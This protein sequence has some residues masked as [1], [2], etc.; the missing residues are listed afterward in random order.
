MLR[1][2]DRYPGR[3]GTAGSDYPDGSYQNESTPGMNNGTPLEKDWAND[4]EGFRQGLVRTV[5]SEPNGIVDTAVQSQALEA[6]LSNAFGHTRPRGMGPASVCSGLHLAENAAFPH[7]SVNRSAYFTSDP[8]DMCLAW[9]YNAD[10]PI[11]LIVNADDELRS[12]S[13]WDYATAPVLSSAWTVSLSVTNY[14]A[15]CCDGDAVYIA[16]DSGGNTRVAKFDLTPWTGT[17][18]WDVDTGYSS[19]PNDALIVANDD[20]VAMLMDATPT[21]TDWRVVVLTKALGTIS[22]GK[23]NDAGYDLE[24]TAVRIT[25]NGT[26]LFWPVSSDSGS[27]SRICSA[28]IA[29]PTLANYTVKSTTVGGIFTDVLAL[30]SDTIAVVSIATSTF[31]SYLRVFHLGIDEFADIGNL[32]APVPNQSGDTFYP[33]LCFDGINIHTSHA[34][35]GNVG[36]DKTTVL[37]RINA[38]RFSRHLDLSGESIAAPVTAL[39]CTNFSGDDA[40]FNRLVFDGRDLWMYFRDETNYSLFRIQAPGIR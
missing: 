7:L 8:R 6:L 1:L 16:Y 32:T 4:R 27:N 5:G 34:V 10:R 21:S 37:R 35:V 17:A 14:H 3:T 13:C 18:L 22:I 36:G 31:I 40:P 23:G 15:I 2:E 39:G 30:N 19:P 38:T 20:N 9:D 29:N 28:T 26:D 25:S 24:S 11:L 12:V 33:K